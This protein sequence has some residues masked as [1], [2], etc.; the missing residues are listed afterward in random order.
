MIN[1]DSQKLKNDKKR[2]EKK[3]T[4]KMCKIEIT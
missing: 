1:D 3:K 4:K 2:M